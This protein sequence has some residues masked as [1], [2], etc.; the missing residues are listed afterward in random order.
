MRKQTH[1]RINYR[2]IDVG[3]FMETDASGS[4]ST[5]QVLGQDGN[6]YPDYTLTPLKIRPVVRVQVKDG[7]ATSGCWNA[8]LANI[9]WTKRVGTATETLSTT[10][11]SYPFLGEANGEASGTLTVK[12]NTVPGQ[13]VVLTF[14]A[15][16]SDPRTG[17]TLPVSAT[18]Q[19][20][21]SAEIE[22]L[23]R[24]RLD[25]APATVF[26]PVAP[27]GTTAAAT[28]MT[29]RARMFK[30][31]RE[32][33]PAATDTAG[34]V[35]F[36]WQHRFGGSTDWLNVGDASK[37]PVDFFCQVSG[38]GGNTLTIDRTCMGDLLEMRCVGLC[39]TTAKPSTLSVRDGSPHACFS[40]RR[41]CS[42]LD[43]DTAMTRD[44]PVGSASVGAK[45]VVRGLAGTLTPSNQGAELRVDWYA[46]ACNAAGNRASS[47]PPKVA[48][49]Y[50]VAIP[51]GASGLNMGANGS[52]VECEVS[53]RG[54]FCAWADADGS[55]LTDTD[56]SV[57]LIR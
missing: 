16:L 30:G 13:P 34:T 36:V 53:D 52:L 35:R 50:T 12:A 2:P 40:V 5:R 44:I 28:V 38:D 15:S 24:V 43:F 3:I 55:I 46:C 49:G 37:G 26:D 22:P 29:V 17:Q 33:P 39:S 8:N 1:I 32:V 25:C 14:E 51:T 10:H 42:E 21:C 41:R 23:G 47:N 56:G 18:V 54:S 20:E 9:R 7:G 27:A 6:H 4:I 48:E 57:L 45:A 11:A 31:A 19:L